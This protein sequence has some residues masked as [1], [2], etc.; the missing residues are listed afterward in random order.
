[1]ATQIY[2]GLPPPNVVK[3]IK[4]HV[5]TGP[6]FKDETQVTYVDG[7]TWEGLIDEEINYVTLEIIPNYENIKEITFG[8][9]VIGI[10]SGGFSSCTSMTTVN[11]HNDI[12]YI[13]FGAFVGCTSLT[14]INIP[15]NP[16]YTHIKSGT[17][18]DCT[19]L[20][21][22]TIPANITNIDIDAF[23]GCTSLTSMIFKGKTLEEVQAMENY[24]WQIGDTSFIKVEA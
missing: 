22:I 5:Q 3:W 14:S 4:E 19:S 21:S 17:F 13:E 18:M 9:N 12:Q 20:S 16:S 7:T 23:S 11:M 10:G 6:V 24:P 2:L 15:I 8:N 1:M